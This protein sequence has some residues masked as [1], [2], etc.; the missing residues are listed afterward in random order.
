MLQR[1]WISDVNIAKPNRLISQIIPLENYKVILYF[2]VDDVVSDMVT[3]Y[4]NAADE[5]STGH[6][7]A[8]G[9]ARLDFRQTA[10]ATLV[11]LS[12]KCVN[13]QNINSYENMSCQ[14]KAFSIE[15]N[16]DFQLLAD[17]TEISKLLY[18]KTYMISQ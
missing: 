12:K 15:K 18:M 11:E 2:I 13:S 5:F 6:G 7:Q 17:P 10:T 8:A 1:V 9:V 16:L 14:G 3:K 4:G